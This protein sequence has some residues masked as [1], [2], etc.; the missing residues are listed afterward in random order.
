[1]LTYTSVDSNIPTQSYNFTFNINEKLDNL[2]ISLLIDNS[3]LLVPYWCHRELKFYLLH[4]V[5][6]V[7]VYCRY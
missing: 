5:K 2:S 3:L 6:G 7:H 4:P 1:M